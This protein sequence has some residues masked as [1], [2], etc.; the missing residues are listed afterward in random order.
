MLLI[1]K[2]GQG[3]VGKIALCREDIWCP[4]EKRPGGIAK[5]R[6]SGLVG[7]QQRNGFALE[8]GV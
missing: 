5:M 7:R 1:L 8:I 6:S 2:L 4:P 3:M